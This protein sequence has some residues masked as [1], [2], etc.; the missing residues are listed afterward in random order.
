[1]AKRGKGVPAWRGGARWRMAGSRSIK[2]AA[3]AL[4]P[5]K[6]SQS[7]LGVVARD[8]LVA[9]EESGAAKKKELVGNNGTAAGLVSS[10]LPEAVP[11]HHCWQ[12]SCRAKSSNFLRCST[13]SAR[14]TRFDLVYLARPHLALDILLPAVRDP[15]SFNK[16]PLSS[17]SPATVH[18]PAE[19]LQ[20]R[21][22]ERNV[23]WPCVTL[24]RVHYPRRR[25]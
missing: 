13:F 19:C 5:Q 10:R 8:T 21:N 4:E 24:H 11:S 2:R 17:E 22:R 16:P 3:L 7:V 23:R 6:L 14:M 20:E 1:M 12:P 25:D 18:L 15:R 9:A